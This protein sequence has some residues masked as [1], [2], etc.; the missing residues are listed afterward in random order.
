M[1]TVAKE[2]VRSLIDEGATMIEVLPE[3]EYSQQHIS[4][5]INIPLKELT[6][7]KVSTFDR[8]RPVVLYCHDFL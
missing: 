8:S 6:E 1:Q 3:E 4:G 2:E 5:A 7:D